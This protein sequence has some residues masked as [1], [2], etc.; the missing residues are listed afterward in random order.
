MQ[1]SLAPRIAWIR[2]KPPIAEQPEP[3][4]ALVAA[5]GRVVEVGAAGALEQVAA[6]RRLVAQL[7]RRAGEQRLRE[8]RIA[9]AHPG[10]GGGVG[11]RR[12]GADP[13]PAVRQ[14]LDL[15]QRQAADVDQVRRLLDLELHQVEQ[16]GAAADEL[17]AGLGHGGDRGPRRRSRARR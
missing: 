11:V 14:L 3:G 17:G 6:D 1:A 2:L 12:L 13:Q 15:L 16:V 7:A 5:G 10:V 9:G 8:H 4:F